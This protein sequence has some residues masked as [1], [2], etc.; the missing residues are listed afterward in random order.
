M[1]SKKKLHLKNI[2]IFKVD[3][4]AIKVST[5]ISNSLSTMKGKD[6]FKFKQ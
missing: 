5:K 3:T 1:Q 6:N 2:P 4:F